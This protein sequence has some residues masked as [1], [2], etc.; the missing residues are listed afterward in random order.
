MKLFLLYLSS[1]SGYEPIAWFLHNLASLSNLEVEVVVGEGLVCVRTSIGECT[2]AKNIPPLF[3]TLCSPTYDCGGIGTRYSAAHMQ[4]LP[5]EVKWCVGME[6][7]SKRMQAAWFNSPASAS[8]AWPI[9]SDR[10]R[11]HGLNLKIDSHFFFDSKGQTF[12]V[13]DVAL[14]VTTPPPPVCRHHQITASDRDP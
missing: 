12:V 6:T 1:W 14:L 5:A 9:K 13:V 8:S 3:P 10:V 11:F 2:I 4:P 7:P